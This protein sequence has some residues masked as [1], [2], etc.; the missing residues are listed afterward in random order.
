[1]PTLGQ[2]EVFIHATEGFFDAQGDVAS[3]GSKTFLQGFMDRFVEW[4]KSH[5]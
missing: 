5:S 1:M 2:P 3:A 4:V